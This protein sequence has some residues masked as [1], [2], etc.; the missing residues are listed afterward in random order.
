MYKELRD[1]YKE[2]RFRDSDVCT[3]YFDSGTYTIYY[4]HNVLPIVSKTPPSLSMSRLESP[5]PNL[6]SNRSVSLTTTSGGDNTW[7]ATIDIL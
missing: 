6:S 1:I 4:K 2:L 5:H 7:I 3:K